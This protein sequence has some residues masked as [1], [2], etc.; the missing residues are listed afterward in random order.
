MITLEII[1]ISG[2]KL[3]AE[4]FE[5]MV[6]TENGIIAILKNH[7]DLISKVKPGILSYRRL[8]D[9]PDDNLDDIAV[10]NGLVVV[11]K[12]TVKVL[13]DEALT[14]DEVVQEEVQEALARAEQL[15]LK[16][17][18]K[19]DIAYAEN[20]IAQAQVKLRVA[21]LRRRKRKT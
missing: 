6:P 4:V 19:Q 2:L 15:K 16:A 18:K 7:D 17:G 8:Q 20:L 13:I 3:E 12:N 11:E 1:T 5:V 21:E 14:P 10:T 9:Q